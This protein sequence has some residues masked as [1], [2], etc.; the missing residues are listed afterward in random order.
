MELL[1]LTKHKKSALLRSLL[2]WTLPNEP[3][4]LFLKATLRLAAAQALSSPRWTLGVCPHWLEAQRLLL[5]K[6][7]FR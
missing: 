6:E 1:P 3:V 2:D 5:W 7:P 4:S